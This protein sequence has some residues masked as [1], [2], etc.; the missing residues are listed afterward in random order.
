M[1]I[2]G[3]NL[4]QGAEPVKEYVSAAGYDRPAG[5]PHQSRSAVIAR[6][7]IVATSQ[8]LASQAGLEVLRA[9]GTAADA[10][11]AANAVLG[12]VEPMSCGIGG[13]LYVIYWDAKAKK[14]YGLNASGRSP[15]GLSRAELRKQGEFI[16]ETGPLS[17]SVPG[18]VSGWGL[19]L[20]RFGKQPLPEIL[21]A[22]I[23]YA[24]GGFPVSEI[25]AADWHSSTK[26]LSRYPTSAATYLPGGHAPRTGEIFRNPR[27][28]ASLRQIAAGGP[29]AFYRGPIADEIVAYSKSVGGYFSADDF[30]EHTADWVEP[31]ST[32]Y[33][34]YDVWEIP[35]PGQGIA[36]LEMLNLLEGY[37]LRSLGH[38]S[39]EYLHRIVEAKKL[40]Y[41]DRARFYADP[42]FADV[43]TAELISKP[44]A[45]RRRRRIDLARAATDVSPGDPRQERG[46]TVYL[47]VVDMDRNCC[48]FIQSNFYGF[49]SQM[50]PGELGFVLQNRGALFSLAD[51]HPN[52]F[53]PGK[54]PFHTIIPAMVTR[55]GQPWLSFGVMGGDMQPQGQVQVLLNMIDFGMNVQQAGDAPRVRHLGSASPTGEPAS[56]EPNVV[57]CESGVSAAAVDGLRAKGHDVRH[58]AGVGGYGGYQGIWIDLEHCT[59]QGGTDPRKDGAAVGY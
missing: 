40:V 5:D 27:L 3:E 39:A 26:S 20:E 15:R 29:N 41:A 37:D 32:N 17:W 22:A 45:E 4:A 13:D 12:V 43:P 58:G 23:D 47:T 50:V 14:L 25:I 9:G 10:A 19:L 55:D 1:G 53:E 57:L 42:K 38:N 34:G 6:H 7:G 52:R 28:A 24:E 51:D 54:R 49:G 18:C 36:V 48:S 31:V 56:A 35:P 2:V 59:L 11:V 33:R 44:Y 16:P 46:D 8:P 21:A 30:A